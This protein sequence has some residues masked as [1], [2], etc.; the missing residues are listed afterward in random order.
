MRD[1]F[2][3]VIVGAG[4]AGCCLAGRLAA[5]GADRIC[6]I[7]AGP[8][9][10][11]WRIRTPAALVKLMRDPRHNWLYST[12]PQP[13][14]G[15]RE[16][17]VPRGKT[18]GGSSAINS[19]V[20]IRGRPTDYDRWVALG[21]SGWGW[22]SALAYFKRSENNLRIKNELHG[23]SGPLIVS[24]LPSP[25]PLCR[26]WIAAGETIGLT[27]NDD[28]NGVSQ[29]GLGVYQVTMQNGRRVSSAHAFLGARDS[30]NLTILTKAEAVRIEFDG[31]SAS[32]LWVRSDGQ[33]RILGVRKELLLCGGAIGSPALLLASGV[34]PQDALDA[35]GTPA[36]RIVDGVGRNLQ[37][38]VSIG[39]SAISN[40]GRG[41]SL[42]TLPGIALAPFEYL[43]RHTGPMTTN[44]VEAGGFA[45][46]DEALDEPDVQFHVIPARVAMGSK[47]ITWGRGYYADVCLLKPRSRGRLTLERSNAG[48]T[49]AIDFAALGHA[50]DRERIVAA[51][52]LLRRILDSAPFRELKAVEESPGPAVRSHEAILDYC[53]RLLGTAY[54]PVGTCR[55]GTSDDPASV[56]DPEL[57]VVGFENMRVVDASVMPEIVAGNT[58]APTIMIAERAADLI[59]GRAAVSEPSASR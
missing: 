37:E 59:L 26:R 5:A 15:D 24:D 23:D 3:Y 20:Y 42:A 48:L 21:C 19:M 51:F 40:A 17:A 18:L 29:E 33:L 14:L 52:R 43:V 36:V 8:D 44:H 35:T 4:S 22:D 28:F 9:D 1:E 25:H 57:R 47:G 27:H 49:P 53:R 55:M 7:E 41:L 46:T 10:R 32:K 13:E 11:S 39:V 16:L 30:D 6:L 34:G 38:H 54:H 45:R 2:D 12:V 56:V 50:E 31:N 58:N